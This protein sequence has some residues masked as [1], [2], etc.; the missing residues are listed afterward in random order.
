MGCNLKLLSLNVDNLS[1]LE[2]FV[3]L[4]LPCRTLALSLFLFFDT[5][6][7]SLCPPISRFSSPLESMQVSTFTN[8]LNPFR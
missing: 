5:D 7:D 4:I 8:C 3:V 6:H 2:I 1:V